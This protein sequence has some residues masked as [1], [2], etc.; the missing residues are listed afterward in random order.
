[1]LVADDFS[2]K[3][4]LSTIVPDRSDID[5]IL[6]GRVTCRKRNILIIKKV[7]SL[8]VEILYGTVKISVKEFEIHTD[9]ERM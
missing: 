8:A 6:A 3:G 1:M 5:R 2:I 4:D 7:R 9:I